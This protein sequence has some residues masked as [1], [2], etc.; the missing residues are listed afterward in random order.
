MCHKFA[1]KIPSPLDIS[2]TSKTSF[3]TKIKTLF[4]KGTALPKYL[5]LHEM[6][7]KT[8]KCSNLTKTEVRKENFES[9]KS[10]KNCQARGL[11]IKFV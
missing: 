6:K 3:N 1:K 5:L 9:K 10:V 2:K 11:L 8:Q 4:L 7:S